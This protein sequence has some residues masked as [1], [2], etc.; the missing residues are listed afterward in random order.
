MLLKLLVKRPLKPAVEWY[1]DS[2]EHPSK[3]VGQRSNHERRLWSM[4]S[5]GL[6]DW[7]GRYLPSHVFDGL[8]STPSG[9]LGAESEING[10]WR[11]QIVRLA[12]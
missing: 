9:R 8:D 10:P 7:I 6:S 3:L 1:F 2:G 11:A 12:A 4:P 5:G